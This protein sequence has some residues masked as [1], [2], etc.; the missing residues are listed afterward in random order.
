MG[1]L[2]KGY[3]YIGISLDRDSTTYK[4]R[5]YIR[6]CLL[7]YAFWLKGCQGS[8]VFLFRQMDD[9]CPF[10]AKQRTVVRIAMNTY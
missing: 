6:L 8:G 4:F 7:Q 1:R 2:Y 3:P 10:R 5:L 9:Y